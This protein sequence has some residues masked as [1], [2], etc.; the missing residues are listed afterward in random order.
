MFKLILSSNSGSIHVSLSFGIVYYGSLLPL[1]LFTCLRLL[2][3]DA[4]QSVSYPIFQS[5]N[6]PNSEE[7]GSRL[8]RNIDKYIP[9]TWRHIPENMGLRKLNLTQFS[10]IDIPLR[11]AYSQFAGSSRSCVLYPGK[12]TPGNY[13][14]NVVCPRCFVRIEDINRSMACCNYVLVLHSLRSQNSNSLLIRRVLIVIFL[15]CNM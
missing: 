12:F 6:C 15:M 5:N 10:F 14:G 2:G 3:C 11:T 4:V 13:L 1:I 8:L 9:L 7:G